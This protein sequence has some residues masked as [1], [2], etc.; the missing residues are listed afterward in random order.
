[1]VTN[2]EI[3]KLI[4]LTLLFPVVFCLTGCNSHKSGND[5]Q[6]DITKDSSKVVQAFNADSVFLR[7]EACFKDK[8]GAYE[9]K[10]VRF[11]FGDIGLSP[12]NLG[13]LL[14]K[15]IREFKANNSSEWHE[16]RV[17]LDIYHRNEHGNKISFSR[18]CDEA[19]LYSYFIEC[20]TNGESGDWDKIELFKYDD[21]AKPFLTSDEQ[22]WFFN[23]TAD[24]QHIAKNAYFVTLEKFPRDL[25]CI[26]KLSDMNSAL[27][28]VKVKSIKL[29]NDD[30]EFMC[31]DISFSSQNPFQYPYHASQS[32]SCN[33]ISIDPKDHN[34]LRK[35]I[36]ASSFKLVFYDARQHADSIIIPIENGLFFSKPDSVFNVEIFK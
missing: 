12:Y 20:V 22:Y 6:K 27:Q 19:R 15:E 31:P 18:N 10:N 23:M 8:E 30:L 16:N 24:N 21:L 25:V 5:H 1:M 33:T 35:Q 32:A 14:V 36:T 7:E 9:F 13:D 3:M 4:N 17:S 2:K 11:Y 28:Q 29:K 34:E 26:L